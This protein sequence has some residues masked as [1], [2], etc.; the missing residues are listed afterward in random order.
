M[1]FICPRCRRICFSEEELREHMYCIDVAAQLDAEIALA[2]EWA[3][4][5]LAGG[6]WT[7]AQ[8]MVCERRERCVRIDGIGWVCWGCR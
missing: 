1:E 7:L 2:Q 8:C 6:V 5:K 3:A 4:A